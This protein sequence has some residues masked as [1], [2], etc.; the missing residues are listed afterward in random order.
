MNILITPFYHG[1]MHSCF[2]SYTNVGRSRA[3]AVCLFSVQ[4][5]LFTNVD[6][7]MTSWERLKTEAGSETKAPTIQVRGRI[8]FT[9]D[10]FEKGRSHNGLAISPTPNPINIPIRFKGKTDSRE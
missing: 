3:G 7:L 6:D 8:R 1:F 2:A 9:R 5:P 4:M 10:R